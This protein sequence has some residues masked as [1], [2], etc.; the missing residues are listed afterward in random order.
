[1]SYGAR[2]N[3]LGPILLVDL[4]EAI[5]RGRYA[6]V[7]AR[8]SLFRRILR[9]LLSWQ[10]ASV[11]ATALGLAAGCAEHTRS[12][13]RGVGWSIGV[14]F[15]P[16]PRAT[17][18]W[19]AEPSSSTTLSKAHSTTL[20]DTATRIRDAMRRHLEGLGAAAGDRM[21]Q[22]KHLRHHPRVRLRP[23]LHDSG[24]LR[25]RRRWRFL[26]SQPL[27]R[28]HDRVREQERGD[29]IRV[30]PRREGERSGALPVPFGAATCMRPGE[31]RDRYRGRGRSGRR[32]SGRLRPGWWRP[33]RGR[34]PVAPWS[35]RR[36]P[37]RRPVLRAVR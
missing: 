28:L 6:C 16:L 19:L 31:V 36:R 5:G 34:R 30:G 7:P 26:P 25:W 2:A 13:D 33:R 17:S 12:I 3:L 37:G 20:R 23:E 15:W 1:V 29:E 35:G 32:R 14:I 10:Q 24:R 4:L 21:P 22:W 11:I 8:A 18:S 27:H 9:L